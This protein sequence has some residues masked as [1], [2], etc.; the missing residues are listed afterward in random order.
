MKYDFDK[1]VNRRNTN[2]SKWNVAENEMP[3]WIADMDF[4]T[5]P[6][7]KEA[8]AKRVGHGVFGYSDIPDE[9]AESYV[10][11][12]KKRH[13]FELRKEAL[14]FC[15]GVIPSLSSC[16]RKLT[17]PAEKVLIQTPVYNIFFNSIVNN[18]RYVVESPLDY[19]EETGKYSMNFVRLE[20][21]LSDPQ[22]SLMVLCNPHNPCGKIWSQEELCR[23]GELCKKYNVTVVS[24]EI[25]CDV[26]EPSKAYVPFASASETCREIS[27][28][29]IAPTK[30]FN[31]AGIHSAAAYAENHQLH[32]KVWRA[33]NTDEVAEP[34]AFAID[35]TIAAFTKGEDWLDELRK[36]LWENRKFAE[37]FFAKNMPALKVI[38]ADATYLMWVD[39]SATGKTGDNF[40]AELREKTGVY[41]SGGSQYG[42]SGENFVRINLACPRSFLEKALICLKSI[43]S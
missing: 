36:Y 5:A 43:Y 27:V 24:D 11:W 3:L 29:C 7:I 40:A 14:I 13:N 21:D 6:C 12:W 35:A 2:S 17:T 25:H 23:V 8:L 37:D 33:L 10:T 28:S 16:V 18:G 22:V 15:T 38:K 4:E 26:T 20:K 31:I 42:K 34:N 1:I 39:V 19:D 30:C 41:I 32:H 9:W